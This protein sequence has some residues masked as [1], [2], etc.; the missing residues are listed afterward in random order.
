MKAYNSVII[1]IL[2]LLLN[3]CASPHRSDEKLPLVSYCDLVAV[4]SQYDGQVVR[5]RASHIVG[6]EWSYLADEKCS[7]DS[8]DANQTWIIIP[9]DAWCDGA[10]QTNTSLPQKYNRSVALEREVTCIP[11]LEPK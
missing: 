7:D 4:P 3:A 2:C 5:V 9:D 1:F 10:T 11:I 6:F 8:P